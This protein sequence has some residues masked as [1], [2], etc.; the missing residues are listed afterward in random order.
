M[1]L[2]PHAYPTLAEIAAAKPLDPPAR[3]PG[4]RLQTMAERTRQAIGSRWDQLG[5][6]SAGM[7]FR[8]RLVIRY[9]TWLSTKDHRMRAPELAIRAADDYLRERDL[10]Q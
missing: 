9:R 2:E 5:A 8:R 4:P 3:R 6:F 10:R 1:K 7:A